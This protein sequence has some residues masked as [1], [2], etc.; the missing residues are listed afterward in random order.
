MRC[1]RYLGT[2]MYLTQVFFFTFQ[3]NSHGVNEDPVGLLHLKKMIKPNFLFG[4]KIKIYDTVTC[5]IQ[6]FLSSSTAIYFYMIF[7]HFS[8]CY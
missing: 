2:Y 3:N 6:F 7:C 5:E 4:K 1:T 8:V